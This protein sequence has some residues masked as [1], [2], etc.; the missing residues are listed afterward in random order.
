MSRRIFHLAEP[1]RAAVFLFVAAGLDYADRTALSSVIPPLKSDLGA[2]DAPIGLAGLV[3]LWS[4]AIAW[5]FAGNIADRF[6]RSRIFFRCIM[7]WSLITV[8]TGFARNMTELLVLRAALGV[9]ESFYLPAAVA[10]QAAHHGPATLGKAM[11]FH[12]IGLNLG[13]FYSAGP[14]SESRRITTAG[15]RASEFLMRWV[16]CSPCF[17]AFHF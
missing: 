13:V 6:S 4:Y 7:I 8:I 9:A 10:L 14:S 16:S 5:S 11:G 12:L 2:T 1:W 3:F 15:G 17:R